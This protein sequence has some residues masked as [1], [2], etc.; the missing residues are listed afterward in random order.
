[1]TNGDP[2]R[3]MEK[4]SSNEEKT[5]TRNQMYVKKSLKTVFHKIN[6]SHAHS[7]DRL[8]LSESAQTTA[9]YFLTNSYFNKTYTI[10]NYL[11]SF[12]SYVCL[13]ISEQR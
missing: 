4:I 5:M 11:A 8:D 13:V 2:D 10:L 12:L 9:L 1:M 7:F 6:I 3:G